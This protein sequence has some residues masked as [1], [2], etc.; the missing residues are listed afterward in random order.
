MTYIQDHEVTYA[1]K[2]PILHTT[3]KMI[4]RFLVMHYT[5]G[6]TAESAINAYRARRVSAHLTVDVDGTVHQ[7][8][9][10]D[11]VAWH[12]GKSRW[13]GYNGLNHYSIGIEIVNAGWFRKD[14]TTYYRDKLR[15]PASQMPPMEPHPHP[16]V[17]GGIFWWPSYTEK[18]LSVVEDLT[19]DILATYDILDIVTHEEIDTRGWKTDPGPA[20]PMDRYKRLLHV[21]NL[22]RDDDSDPYQV[23]AGTLNVRSGPDANFEKIG[24]VHR[25]DIVNVIDERGVW[26]RIDQDGNDDGWV[27]GGYLRRA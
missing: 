7:H 6:F 25:G 20:F 15:K 10:F 26:K 27:H 24:E 1:K 23:T 21:A 17:G 9:P 13:M 22:N 19:E 18:Q 5:A 14:G 11:T 16:R 4:P 8:V 12:A 3:Q 2:V